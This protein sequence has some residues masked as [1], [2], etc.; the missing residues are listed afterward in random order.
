MCL[1]L[2]LF[3]LVN[4]SCQALV[5][6]NGTGYINVYLVGVGWDVGRNIS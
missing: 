3:K 5:T 4:L 6:T 2:M 1:I